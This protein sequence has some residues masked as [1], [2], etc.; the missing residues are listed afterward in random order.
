MYYTASG[1][2]RTPG[3]EGARTLAEPG[4]SAVARSQGFCS[5][6]QGED[7]QAGVVFSVSPSRRLAESGFKGSSL[8]LITV[9]EGSWRRGGRKKENVGSSGGGREGLDPG[10]I[11][12][13]F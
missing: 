6:D 9:Q 11:P 7:A 4:G 10:N 2:L 13:I 12:N 8:G 1:R 3:L 5:C